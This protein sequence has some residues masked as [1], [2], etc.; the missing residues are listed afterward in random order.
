MKKSLE[1]LLYKYDPFDLGEGNYPTEMSAILN[2]M[3]IHDQVTPLAQ[4]IG[5]VFE[6]SFD[7]QPDQQELTTLAT[8]LLLCEDPCEL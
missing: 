1:Q 5:D 4:A 2:L 6:E 3:T 8:N 7:E